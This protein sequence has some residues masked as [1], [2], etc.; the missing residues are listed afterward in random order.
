M[1]NIKSIKNVL[2]CVL[3]I[4]REN[5]GELNPGDFYFL[6]VVQG[7]RNLNI[8]KTKSFPINKDTVA[9]SWSCCLELCLNACLILLK[10]C[11]FWKRD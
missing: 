11:F 6:M 4:F 10:I 8:K 1:I 7:F 5:A 9:V 2:T 3:L